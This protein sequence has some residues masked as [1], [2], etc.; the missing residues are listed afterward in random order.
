[1]GIMTPTEWERAGKLATLLQ[2]YARINNC[3]IVTAVQQEKNWSV[4]NERDILCSSVD[5]ITQSLAKQY[6]SNWNLVTNT[7][8]YTAKPMPVKMLTSKDIQHSQEIAIK[9]ESK[10]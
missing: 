3:A 10:P 5:G 2:D 8:W 7:T 9:L 4:Y 6:S 1:M